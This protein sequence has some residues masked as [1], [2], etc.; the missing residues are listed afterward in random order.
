MKWLWSA[1]PVSAATYTGTGGGSPKPFVNEILFP[2]GCSLVLYGA[3]AL[4]K[5]LSG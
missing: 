4:G 1:K 2:I 5:R 3:E